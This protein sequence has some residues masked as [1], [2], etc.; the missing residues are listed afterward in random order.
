MNVLI[1][2]IRCWAT[3]SALLALRCAVGSLPHADRWPGETAPEC[4][5]MDSERLE[6]IDRVV[7]Q[8][9]EQRQ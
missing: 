7:Q 9:I 8:A 1:A 4:V 2:L 3:A 5:G 6:Q